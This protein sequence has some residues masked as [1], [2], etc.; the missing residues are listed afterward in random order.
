MS[1]LHRD[2]AS[3]NPLNYTVKDKPLICGHCSNDKFTMQHIIIHSQGEL[4]NT[5]VTCFVCSEC[6]HMEW[7]QS[8]E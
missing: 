8:T 5:A 6:T 2:S 3:V 1:L 4:I 7:F